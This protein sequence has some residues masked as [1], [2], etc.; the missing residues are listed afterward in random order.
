MATNT[1]CPALFASIFIGLTLVGKYDI[2]LSGL[3]MWLG[4][5]KRLK[6]SQ[7]YVEEFEAAITVLEK[8]GGDNENNEKNKDS[9][10][11]DSGPC[12]IFVRHGNV[13]D[14][15]VDGPGRK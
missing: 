2:V 13:G 10:S 14:E 7:C 6:V 5:V 15:G 9:V 4:E 8:E 11:S 12:P 3:R 1:T